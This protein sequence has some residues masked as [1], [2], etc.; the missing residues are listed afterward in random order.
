MLLAFANERAPHEVYNA[1]YI[2][3]S[4]RETGRRLAG[5]SL[6]IDVIALHART[7]HE[8]E[9]EVTRNIARSTLLYS[10]LQLLL[11][12]TGCPEIWYGA[13]DR[14]HLVIAD[15]IYADQCR[16]NEMIPL[17]VDVWI[18]FHALVPRRK[19]MR[20]TELE[21]GLNGEAV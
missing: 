15:D 9:Q 16:V 1:G 21:E 5:G 17:E 14:R 8:Q 10:K 18:T 7:H 11:A 6:D 4:R 19:V 20:Y 12:R 3:Y 2:L 13:N